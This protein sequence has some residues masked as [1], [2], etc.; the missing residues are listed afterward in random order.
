MKLIL[1]I[2]LFLLFPIQFAIAQTD[3]KTYQEKI[4]KEV[5]NYDS[6]VRVDSMVMSKMKFRGYTVRMEYESLNKRYLRKHR[7]RYRMGKKLETVRVYSLNMY[8]DK[9]LY[10]KFKKIDENY[11]R[12]EG[13]N[14][15][16][17]IVNE[18]LTV[19]LKNEKGILVKRHFYNP[20]KINR[21]K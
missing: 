15:S 14:G 1:R 9:I 19:Y 16:K 2:S 8:G 17:L 5:E 4:F 21:E 10:L 6:A 13:N 18:Y 11:T 20:Q 12:I 7:A 3:F